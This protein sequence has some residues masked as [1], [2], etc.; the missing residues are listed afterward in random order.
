MEGIEEGE[1][2][3]SDTR[4]TWRRCTQPAGVRNASLSCKGHCVCG[5]W[6]ESGGVGMRLVALLS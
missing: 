1:E 3:E 5:G 6:N 4:Q 2:V